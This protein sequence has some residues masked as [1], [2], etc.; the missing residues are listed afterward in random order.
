[1]HVVSEGGSNANIETFFIK[2]KM[3]EQLRHTRFTKLDGRLLSSTWEYCAQ[4]DNSMNP[5]GVKDRSHKRPD[6]VHT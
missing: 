5:I 1:M 3:L 2:E 4:Q 6:H